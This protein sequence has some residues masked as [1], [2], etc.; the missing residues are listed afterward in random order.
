MTLLITRHLILSGM[1]V[2]ALFLITLVL[3]LFARRDAV[4]RYRLMVAALFTAAA[5][6]PLQALTAELAPRLNLPPRAAVPYAPTSSPGAAPAF[7]GYSASAQTETPGMPLAPVAARRSGTRAD[8][9]SASALL[10]MYVAG[11]LIVVGFHAIRA[12]TVRRLLRRA[13]PV[14]DTRVLQLW[15]RLVA[16]PRRL[17]ELLECDGLQT[18]A[19]RALGRPAVIV[20]AASGAL[21]DDLLLAALQHELIH[22]R[23]RDGAVALL[24]AAT[25]AVLW[26]QPLVWVFARVLGA[27]REYSCDALVVRAS[28]RP[29]SYAMALLRFCDP[30]ASARRAMPLIGF[31]SA[32]S[33]R[34]RISMLA[35]AL[36][37]AA[38]PRH[39]LVLGVGLAC[40]VSASA[41]HA[42]LTAAAGP[43][44]ALSAEPP[45]SAA[46]GSP[47]T[48]DKYQSDRRMTAEV[49][50]AAT[51]RS[52]VE[53]YQR[54]VSRGL[55]VPDAP[56]PGDAWWSFSAPVDN[57]FGVHVTESWVTDQDTVLSAT[58][59][60]VEGDTLQARQ[61]RLG[62]PE[63]SKLRAVFE[64]RTVNFEPGA[65]NGSRILVTGGTVRIVDDTGVTRIQVRAASSQDDATLALTSSA[66]AGEFNFELSVTDGS[67][68]V[69]VRLD[70]RTGV[71]PGEGRPPHG[72]VRW[73]LL[74]PTG[75]SGASEL[76]MQ[77]IYDLGQLPRPDGC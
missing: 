32:R 69:S 21:D 57:S 63:G 12:M 28:R 68:P 48:V 77:R 61:I 3:R 66:R 22:L 15:E 11:A 19:C 38:R 46:G 64:G 44:P 1:G 37:P 47:A 23:R 5:L 4:L 16:G 35:H 31:E 45:S 52:D 27:D 33:I 29:R 59:A 8:A 30:V 67:T 6:L 41:A 34:R 2:G 65:K 18:P 71:P 50:A 54:L 73:K 42:L 40:L 58:D 49:R 55:I 56:P 7:V 17:P 43:G 14:T 51:G 62:L 13:R 74:V 72:A 36:Q 70:T 20:P 24:A 10:D 39:A 76:K 75:G 60:R 9:G 26:F 25:T 53:V